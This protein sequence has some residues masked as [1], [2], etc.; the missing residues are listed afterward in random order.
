M[1][2]NQICLKGIALTVL[3]SLDVEGPTVGSTIH[4]AGSPRV[5]KEVSL[6]RAECGSK[7]A[8]QQAALSMVSISS[9]A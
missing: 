5:Y 6:A 8:N 9:S 2:Q 1:A 7:P 4:R 3:L